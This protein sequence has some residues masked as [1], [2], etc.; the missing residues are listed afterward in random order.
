MF[1]A[2]KALSWLC[3]EGKEQ[4]GAFSDQQ[5]D[6]QNG[7]TD[8]GIDISVL[9]SGLRTLATSHSFIIKTTM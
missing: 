8:P 5:G 1:A 6:R 9:I 3:C 2:P 7:Q 4:L